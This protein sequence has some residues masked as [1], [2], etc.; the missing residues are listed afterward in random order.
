MSSI[1]ISVAEIK[2]GDQF[3]AAGVHHW[4]ATSDPVIQA[5]DGSHEVIVDVRFADGGR[6]ERVWDQGTMITVVREEGGQ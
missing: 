6:G 5:R 4:T 3:E 1:N 2:A